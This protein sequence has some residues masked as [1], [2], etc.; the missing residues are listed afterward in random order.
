MAGTNVGNMQRSAA[1][2]RDS[3]P[4]CHCDARIVGNHVQSQFMPAVISVEVPIFDLGFFV[5]SLA[6]LKGTEKKTLSKQITC[7]KS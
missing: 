6:D 3:H 5:E 1:V 7:I 2:V 4:L